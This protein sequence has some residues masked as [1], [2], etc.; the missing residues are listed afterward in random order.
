MKTSLGKKPVIL[1]DVAVGPTL[2]TLFGIPLLLIVV[3][4]A[5]IIVTTVLIRRARRKN[6][7]Q[8]DQQIDQTPDDRQ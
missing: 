6:L 5:I 3:V 2:L 1:Y 8:Q 4:A 7:K